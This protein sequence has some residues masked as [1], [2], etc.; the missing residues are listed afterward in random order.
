M[1]IISTY[2]LLFVIKEGSSRQALKHE[3]GRRSHSKHCC[4]HPASRE[5]APS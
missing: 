5:N 3:R 1:K 4:F 2:L